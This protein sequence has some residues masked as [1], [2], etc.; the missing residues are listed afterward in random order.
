MIDFIVKEFKY[1]VHL[2]SLM[3]LNL[4]L[5]LVLSDLKYFAF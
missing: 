3:P 1:C 4:M 2:F 5:N